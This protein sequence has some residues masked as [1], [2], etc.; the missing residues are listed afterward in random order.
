MKALSAGGRV[1]PVADLLPTALP[2]LLVLAPDYI[3]LLLNPVLNV[4]LTWPKDYAI[5]DI[6]KSMFRFL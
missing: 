4:S 5:H 6:G 3:P 2:A 1:S